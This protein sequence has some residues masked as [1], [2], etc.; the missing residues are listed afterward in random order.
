MKA[1][2]TES[3]YIRD[4]LVL[5]RFLEGINHSQVR[6]DLR[7]RIGD[8]D[9]KIETVLERALHTEAVTRIE[10]EQQTPKV[11]V[12]RRDETKDLVE[13]VSKL[14]NQLSVDDKQLENRRKQSRERSSSRGR[15]GDDK[16]DRGQQQ[17]RGFNDRRRFPKPGP[18]RK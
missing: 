8:K 6:L 5:R 7:K 4:H 13:A 12:I 2:P 11:A 18:S 1:Y 14:V 10:K 9:R 15:W 17:D 16:R 3:H